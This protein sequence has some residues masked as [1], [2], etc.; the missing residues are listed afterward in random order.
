M[1]KKYLLGT[2]LALALLLSGSSAQAETSATVTTTADNSSMLE[3]IKSLL[4]QVEELQ[5]Q[6]ATVRGEIQELRSDLREGVENDD[7]RKVQELLATDPTLYPKGKITG[8]YGPL[9]KEAVM[10]FQKRHGLPE[11]GVVDEATKKLIEDYLKKK[12]DKNVAPG[13]IKAYGLEKKIE[14]K[15]WENT[16]VKKDKVPTPPEVVKNNA[17]SLINLASSVIEDLEDQIEDAK[18]DDDADDVEEA[19][20]D[21]A[22]AK[23]ELVTAKGYFEDEE[24]QKA[25]DE[26]YKAKYSAYAGIE[27]L[28]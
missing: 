7:V 14:D 28:K 4:K 5:K 6:L 20:E 22:R 23:S 15:K 1:I 11:T 21:L 18:D 10:A 12:T 27:E 9:T 26:A 19:E 8:Y 16:E 25:F 3:L 13:W 2:T 24:W 17:D